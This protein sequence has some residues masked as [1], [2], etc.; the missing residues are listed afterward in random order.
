ITNVTYKERTL[1]YSIHIQPELNSE[2]TLEH[3]H[4][5]NLRVS[6]GSTVKAGDI[7]G[8]VGTLGGELGRT[9]IMFWNSSASRPLT[10]C[11]LKYFDPQL[12]SEYKQKV[13]QHMEDWEEFKG[14]TN[15]YNEEKHL[16]PG[17]LYE[18]LLE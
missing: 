1:D 13:T 8:K 2:W 10:Y 17:C 18:S 7:L 11:P 12:L 4:V 9:E 15:L 3:D 6:K 16:F 5:S 14:N